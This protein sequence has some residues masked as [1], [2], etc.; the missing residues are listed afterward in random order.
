MKKTLLLSILMLAVFQISTFAQTYHEDDKEGLRQL[1]RQETDLGTEDPTCLYSMFNLTNKDTLNWTTSEDWITKLDKYVKWDQSSPARITGIYYTFNF[2]LEVPPFS[3]QKF[4]CS[5]FPNIKELK[6]DGMSYHEINLENCS[7][8]EYL[9]INLSCDPKIDYSQASNLKTVILYQRGVYLLN[10]NGTVD[11]SKNI[12]ITSL[13]LKRSSF[14]GLK[15][16]PNNSKLE[17]ITLTYSDLTIL[18]IENLPL[19][20]KIILQGSHKFEDVKLVNLNA[21]ESFSFDTYGR[22][23][24]QTFE[25]SSCPAITTLDLSTYQQYSF[26][27]DRKNTLKVSDCKKLTT[28]NGNYNS[29]AYIKIENC[30]EMSNLFVGLNHLEEIDATINCPKILECTISENT[31]LSPLSVKIPALTKLLIKNTYLRDIKVGITNNPI[32]ISIPNT[33]VSNLD[34]SECINLEAL[35]CSD[36]Y[37]LKNIDLSKNTKIK[38][39]TSSNTRL[40]NVDLSKNTNLSYIDLSRNQL[41]ELDLSKNINLTYVDISENNLSKLDLAKQSKLETIKASNNKFLFSTLVLP[42]KTINKSIKDMDIEITYPASVKE[43]IDLSSEYN[44]NGSITSFSWSIYGSEIKIEDKANGKFAISKGFSGKTLTCTMTNAYYPEWVQ[45]FTYKVAVD[46][47]DQLETIRNFLRQPSSVEGKHNIDLVKRTPLDTTQWYKNNDWIY[48]LNNYSYDAPV[49]LTVQYDYS[50]DYQINNIT[51]IT[52]QNSSTSDANI[53]IGGNID[54][55][56]FEA[57]TSLKIKNT[58]IEQIDLSKNTKLT[59]LVLSNNKLS[60]LDVS[61]LDLLK[62]D[63]S[64][65]AIE[66]LKLPINNTLSELNCSRNQL[67]E[68]NII[69]YT[70]LYKLDCSSNKLT[71]I[72][73]SELNNLYSFNASNNYLKT[74]EIGKNSLNTIIGIDN[75]NMKLSTLPI[76]TYS[77]GYWHY[78]PQRDVNEGKVAPN[79]DIDLSLEAK[80]G[81]NSSFFQWVDKDGKDITAKI[82]NKGGG[83]FVIPSEFL[84]QTLTCKIQNETFPRLEMNHIFKVVTDVSGIEEGKSTETGILIY[85]NPVRDVINISSDIEVVTA[86]TLFDISGRILKAES[87][88]IEQINVSDLPKGFYILKTTTQ[89]GKQSTHKIKKQ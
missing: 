43:L 31:S 86:A 70:E 20:K 14:D 16:P 68:L 47:V 30:P 40:T 12:N 81:T 4:D 37:E 19:L 1:L 54:L 8:L 34:L 53:Y 62:L 57:L 80:I 3:V 24:Y 23:N 10:N 66:T 87:G 33:N 77:L 67:K 26:E 42:N 78:A 18:N 41:S 28:I 17:T 63:C 85:P 21:L 7:N 2:D 25:I 50:D 6:V 51:N 61:Y 59:S 56:P 75:N 76:P 32:S 89:S 22:I 5:K 83:K 35:D 38:N 73:I 15:L 45:E 11:L 48:D 49:I 29:L 79:T 39:L 69:N 46:N 82:T 55:T 88:N 84:D 74:L 13:E 27:Y 44:I 9:N 64:D 52:I 71:S 58:S 65:N 72:D 36:N 60:I